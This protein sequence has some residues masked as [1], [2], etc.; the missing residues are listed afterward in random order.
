MKWLCIIALLLLSW[1]GA[2]SQRLTINEIGFKLNAQDRERITLLSEYE[3]AL[4]N[5]LF[6]TE[7][8]DTL[9]IVIDIYNKKSE[10]IKA[11]HA[12]GMS[13]VPGTG[14]YFPNTDRCLVYKDDGFID[15]VVHEMGH[16]FL[17]HNMR[18]PPRWLG[19]GL[20]EF[21]ESLNVSNGAVVVTAQRGRM[22]QVKAGLESN[23]FNLREFVARGGNWHSKSQITGMYNFAYSI[24]Y[25]IMKTDPKNL[26]KIVA[27]L[28]EQ[29]DSVAAIESVYGSVES[30]EA[31]YTTFCRFN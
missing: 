28:K 21:F 3:A 10:Y 27:A 18:R 12:A 29:N 8:N 25:F 5:E 7:L 30:F 23:M 20:S 6:S 11:C 1:K 4:Y 15:V 26:K 24:I 17:H 13:F 14:V 9:S 22:Y 16:A 19:E 31:S 2:Y